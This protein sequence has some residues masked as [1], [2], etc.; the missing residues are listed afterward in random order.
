[1][2][3]ENILAAAQAAEPKVKIEEHREAVQILRDKGYT[4]REISD[5]LNKQ[6]VRTD[7]T[8]IYR[9]FG[10]LP[11]Q[12]P[13]ESRRLEIEKITYLGQRKTK[14]NNTWNVL[15]LE[16]PSKLGQSITL[17]GH[18]WKMGNP[19]FAFQDVGLI[20]FRNASLVIKSGNKFP[21]AYIQLEFKIEGGA[22]SS[23]DVYIMP[24]WDV[25]L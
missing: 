11:K 9:T 20:D 10:K 14:R 21:F 25:L 22:W 1:M 18:A 5:F 7:H 6:G 15:E 2:S 3:R 13:P 23:Q 4:W 17:V 24:K 19:E 12:S 16:V 8:R